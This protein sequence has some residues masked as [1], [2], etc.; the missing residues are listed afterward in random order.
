MLHKTIKKQEKYA[1]VRD[2]SEGKYVYINNRPCYIFSKKRWMAGKHGALKF[3]LRIADVYE[4][5]EIEHIFRSDGKLELVKYKEKCF[6]RSSINL[7]LVDK[8]STLVCTER[9]NSQYV[10]SIK[11][12]DC[13]FH[14]LIKNSINNIKFIK[15]MIPEERDFDSN[16]NKSAIISYETD[17]CCRFS[18][19]GKIYDSDSHRNLRVYK[20]VEIPLYICE[21]CLKKMKRSKLLPTAPTLK[22]KH[23]GFCF[24]CMR[25]CLLYFKAGF[26]LNF[27]KKRRRNS[28]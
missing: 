19:W 28:F 15:I 13:S 3:C 26:N 27:L 20:K 11:L 23:N 4:W 17:D 18:N 25:D 7:I 9:F 24:D 6:Y 16:I 21:I 5:K 8:T 14:N 1:L 10:L 22:N 2:I 12:N